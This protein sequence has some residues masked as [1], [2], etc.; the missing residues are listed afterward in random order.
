MTRTGMIGRVSGLVYWTIRGFD[1][2]LLVE[3]PT[4]DNL[5]DDV[6]SHGN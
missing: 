2:R 3:L 4:A 1:V 5:E 6:L